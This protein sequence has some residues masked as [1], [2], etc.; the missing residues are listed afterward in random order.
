MT[1]KWVSEL[2][3]IGSDD[4]LSPGR[5]L[6]IIWAKAG[7]LL[8][9][10][11]GTNFSKILSDIHTFLFKKMHLKMSSATWHQFCL[12]LDMFMNACDICRG[13]GGYMSTDISKKPMFNPPHPALR[14]DDLADDN[15]N[16]IL[17]KENILIL[18]AY[19]LLSLHG[20]VFNDT[21]SL[22]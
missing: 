2:T 10:T 4:G 8:I 19:L 1:H 11:L 14:W 17:L 5:R 6:A 7:I 18:T 9:R 15:I 3:I 16:R 13:N 20:F 21:I 12:G 22:I